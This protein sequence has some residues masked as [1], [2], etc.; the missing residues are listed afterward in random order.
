MVTSADAMPLRLLARSDQ[1]SS[2]QTDLLDDRWIIR[3]NGHCETIPGG[4]YVRVRVLEREGA[5]GHPGHLAADG[6]VSC[7]VTIHDALEPF[8]R[9]SGHS[10][11][12]HDRTQLGART[13]VFSRFPQIVD[14][15]DVVV[16]IEG[17]DVAVILGNAH[18]SSCLGIAQGL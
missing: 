11:E 7:G 16:M 13:P 18:A 6:G 3:T 4:C 5:L 9:H 17:A 14:G 2:A 15:D 8:G 12:D 10:S 1:R